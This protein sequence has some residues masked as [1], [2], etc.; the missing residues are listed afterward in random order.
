MATNPFFDPSPAPDRASVFGHLLRLLRTHLEARSAEQFIPDAELQAL[1][2][3]L[4]VPAVWAR[5]KL[6]M[7][8]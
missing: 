8:L 4:A 1:H 7:G 6:V 5:V 2:P 3:L